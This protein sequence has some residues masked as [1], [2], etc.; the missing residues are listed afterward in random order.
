LGELGKK[1][2]R[3]AF[4]LLELV[5]DKVGFVRD[6]AY[7]ALKEVVG[8]LRYAELDNGQK[9]IKQTRQK[10]VDSKRKAA[11]KNRK[12]KIRNHKS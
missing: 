6:A 7:R 5:I 11:S 4:A 3:V 1:E 9:R 8:N 12:S 2:T 10:A